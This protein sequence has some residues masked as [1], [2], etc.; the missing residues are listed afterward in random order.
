M[1]EQNNLLTVSSSPHIRTVEKTNVLMADVIIAL[2]PAA[3]WGVYVFGLRALSIIVLSIGTCVLCEFFYNK[4]LHK[5]Q[6]V[7]DLSAIV[8]GLLL[9]MNLPSSV[10]LYIPVLGAFFAIVVVKMLFGGIGKNIANPA[11]AARVFLF[12]SWSGA[13]TTYTRPFERGMSIFGITAGNIA[14]ITAAATPLKHMKNAELP[15]IKIF[16]MFIGNMP[17]CIG[18]I[19]AALLLLG[20]IYLLVRKTITW[21]I[22]V[23]YIGTVIVLTFL[24]PKN[25]SIHAYE[26]MLYELLSGGLFLAAIFMATDYTTS[27]VSAKGQLIYGFGCGAITVFIRYFGGYSEGASFA[28]LIMNMLV[29]YID[30][31]TRPRIFGEKKASWIKPRG[32]GG[33]TD[34]K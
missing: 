28:I 31:L 14:D 30:M 9:A 6:T 20:G 7:G 19:S 32:N 2:I 12:V 34:E 4:L 1:D 27:P 18:E 22:P 25:P 8:T 29:W 17:G 11:L 24:F 16:D 3:V 33:S 23:S 21:H 26:F 10:P 15:G 13:M 5:K